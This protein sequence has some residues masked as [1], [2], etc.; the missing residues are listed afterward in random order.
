MW[1]ILTGSTETT[2]KRIP[3]HATTGTTT[4]IGGVHGL[5]ASQLANH[6]P[7]EIGIERCD[8]WFAPV[9][10]SPTSTLRLTIPENRTPTTLPNLGYNP[11]VHTLRALASDGYPYVFQTL[12]Q[13]HDRG[14]GYTASVHLA[15]FNCEHA[16]VTQRFNWLRDLNK[17]NYDLAAVYRPAGFLSNESL[18]GFYAETSECCDLLRG[19]DGYRSGYPDMVDYPK[20]PVRPAHLPMLF[21]ILPLYYTSDCWES[22]TPRDAPTLVT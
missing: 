18:F 19:R 15:V 5:I 11:F 13:R 22:S 2:Q 10:V 1:T 9:G 21:D 4:T 6:L 12:L 3:E 8:L 17:Y 7:E 14:G 16:A 20:M